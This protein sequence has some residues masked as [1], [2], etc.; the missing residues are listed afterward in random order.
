MIWHLS[1]G[2]QPAAAFELSLGET[3]L[4]DDFRRMLVE[5]PLRSRA[6]LENSGWVRH[7]LESALWGLLTT[8][9]FEDAVI[10]VVN[11][12]S[13]AD[14]AGSVA[15]ALAGAAYGLNAIPQEW[16]NQ[17]RG[18]WPLGSGRFWRTP[19]F[20]DLA[21]RLVGLEGIQA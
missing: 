1:Q 18:E 21:D 3:S 20:I 17:L 4:P 16:R 8:R 5:A 13:D 14:T 10:Q 7:T 15:G 2:I 12:G 19:D 11:L 6:E 9:S